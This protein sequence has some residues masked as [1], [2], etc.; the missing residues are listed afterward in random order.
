MGLFHGDGTPNAHD[1]TEWKSQFGTYQP[2]IEKIIFL[3][4]FLTDFKLA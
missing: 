3:R 1:Y 2:D 4:E